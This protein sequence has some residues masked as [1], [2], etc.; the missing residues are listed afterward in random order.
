MILDGRDVQA[1][2]N[3]VLRH[4]ADGFAADLDHFREVPVHQTSGP[5]VGDIQRQG[6]LPYAQSL[7]LAFGRYQI[8]QLLDD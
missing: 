3:V 2:F 7:L 8:L 5:A 4:F 1:V 6:S